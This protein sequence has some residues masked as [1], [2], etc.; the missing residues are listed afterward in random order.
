MH[1]VPP[2]NPA[3][4]PASSAEMTQSA[5]SLQTAPK[6]KEEPEGK[7]TWCCP[8]HTTC[9]FHLFLL[10]AGSLPLYR[11][12]IRWRW[13]FFVL[14]LLKHTEKMKNNR[15]KAPCCP[16]LFLFSL[17]LL[18]TTCWHGPRTKETNW[19][20]SHCHWTSLWSLWELG[21]FPALKAGYPEL[22]GSLQWGGGMLCFYW[23]LKCW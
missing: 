2:P 19:L 16:K 3:P 21:C 14:Q 6:R 23:G 17:W 9:S 4:R 22:P 13:R 1:T 15:T 5:S 7:L 8:F 11:N 20:S 12:P 18:S 10:T